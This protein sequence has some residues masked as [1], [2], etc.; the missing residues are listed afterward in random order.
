M[1]DEISFSG[2][3]RFVKSCPLREATLFLQFIFCKENI[4]AS[5]DGDPILTNEW[6]EV[7]DHLWVQDHLVT[8]VLKHFD[9]AKDLLETLVT[10]QKQGIQAKKSEKLPTEPV[11]FTL[12][13]PNARKFK[14]PNVLISTNFKAKPVPK[15]NYTGTGEREALVKTRESRVV[16]RTREFT[17]TKRN[18]IKKE[19]VLMYLF[20]I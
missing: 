14:E 15:S 11:P 13:I 4:V 2:Y 10:I 17:M 16:T 5:G 19:K 8:R 18:E 12:T 9:D 7:Y 3:V 20:N 6:K 1:L